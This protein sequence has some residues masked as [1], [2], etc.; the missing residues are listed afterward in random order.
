MFRVIQKIMPHFFPAHFQEHR[1]GIQL[2]RADSCAQ[3]AE[4]ALEGHPLP[5]FISTVKGCR[6]FSRRSV[7]PE[8][9][10]SLL[11]CGATGAFSTDSADDAFQDRFGVM[12]PAGIR[13]VG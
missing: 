6:Y 1:V 13:W 9:C 5:G 10:T 4:T 7:L 11:A 12:M 8:K 3:L 2:D